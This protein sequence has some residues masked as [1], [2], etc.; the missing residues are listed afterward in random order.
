MESLNSIDVIDGRPSP[1]AELLNRL[2]REAGHTIE[3]VESTDKICTLKGTRKDTGESQELS[4]SIED[5]TKAGLTSRPAW[6]AYP[7]DLLWA[8]T[9][10]RLHKRLFPDV[11]HSNGGI[12]ADQTNAPEQPPEEGEGGADL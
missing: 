4:F 11:G 12:S 1:S 5:A 10:S 6:K 8:R 3:V 2:I 9:V 7:G